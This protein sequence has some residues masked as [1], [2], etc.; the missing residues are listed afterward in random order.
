VWETGR[1]GERCGIV[2]GMMRG[3]GDWEGWREILESEKD[4][5]IVGDWE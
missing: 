3:V 1:G 5:Q 2:V 4:G